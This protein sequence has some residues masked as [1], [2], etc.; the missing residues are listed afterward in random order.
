MPGLEAVGWRSTDGELRTIAVR[1][2][3]DGESRVFSIS[4]DEIARSQGEDAK[5]LAW[6][7][8]D[9]ERQGLV[10]I[11]ELVEH[12]GS[13]ISVKRLF[14][15]AGMPPPTAERLVVVFGEKMY[16]A[17][18]SEDARRDRN[19]P[20][21]SW[22]PLPAAFRIVDWTECSKSQRSDLHSRL[23][24][25]Q[26][27]PDV[28]PFRRELDCEPRTSMAIIRDHSIVGWLISHRYED[29]ILRQTVSYIDPRLQKLGLIY[30]AYV[31]LIRRIVDHL[32]WET[33]M[34]F[35]VDLELARGLAAVVR[36]RWTMFA[37]SV[38]T[39]WKSTIEPP[40]DSRR[41]SDANEMP[42]LGSGGFHRA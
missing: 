21:G 41:R 28:D 11:A 42:P 36:R 20:I 29:G 3:R 38:E 16:R 35:T 7:R 27:Y 22:R 23:E 32:G 40:T 30:P 19:H 13:G 10:F 17:T 26:A 31:E 15:R 1:L 37:D 6:M 2:H 4:G 14:E 8:S 18:L 12:A 24:E 39:A 25:M 9:A 5:L 33:Q 34:R